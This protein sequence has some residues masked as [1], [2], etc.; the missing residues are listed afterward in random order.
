MM[1]SQTAAMLGRAGRV[2]AVVGR[3]RECPGCHEL[4][5]VFSVGG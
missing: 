4:T 5:V 1:P 2:F 3:E